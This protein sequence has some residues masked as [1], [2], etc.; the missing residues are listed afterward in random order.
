MASRK[1]DEKNERIIRGLLKLLKNHRCSNCN[2][3]REGVRGNPRCWN[4]EIEEGSANSSTAPAALLSDDLLGREKV[5]QIAPQL[6]QRFSQ[7]IFWAVKSSTS[8]VMRGGSSVR[9]RVWS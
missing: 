2:N 1:E 6:Q 8:T 4:V 7:T 3:L 9:W 5:Q